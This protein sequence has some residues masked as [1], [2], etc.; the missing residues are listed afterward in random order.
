LRLRN[1]FLS[2]MD[3]F[4]F[5]GIERKL[6]LDSALL[7]KRF[8]ELSREYHPDR[9]AQRPV[10]DRLKAEQESALLNDAY[11]TLRD[12]LQRAEYVLK[13]EGYDIGEQRSKDVPPD[14]LEEVFELNMALEELRGGDTDARAQLE[15]AQKKFA[16]MRDSIDAELQSLYAAYDA[17]QQRSTLEQVRAVLN[18][19]RY[20]RNLINEVEKELGKSEAQPTQ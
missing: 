3:Y 4:Q 11:R 6:A 2:L 20:V 7:Q 8:Y 13:Q 18:R 14:L 17:Q 15:Q 10:A 1:L 12:H 19:R 9:F 16:A 5:F